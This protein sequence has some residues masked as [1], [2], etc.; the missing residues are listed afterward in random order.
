MTYLQALEEITSEL[1]YYIGSDYSQQNASATAKRIRKGT[2]TIN[3]RNRFLNTFGYV[4]QE[5]EWVKTKMEQ[6]KLKT[7]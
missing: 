3:A 4:E 1:K 2:A 6:P 7:K 5:G